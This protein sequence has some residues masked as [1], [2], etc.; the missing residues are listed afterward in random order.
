[1]NNL[2]H[3]GT[4]Y[5]RIFNLTIFRRSFG[6][7]IFRDTLISRLAL[8]CFLL[9]NNHL[10]LKNSI[11]NNHFIVKFVIN[12]LANEITNNI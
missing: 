3:P 7:M 8:I 11:H 4:C 5:F 10:F 9:I 2:C 1:M 12:Y 6:I